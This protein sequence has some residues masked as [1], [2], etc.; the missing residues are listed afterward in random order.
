M[1]FIV[2]GTVVGPQTHYV[3]TLMGGGQTFGESASTLD[4]SGNM[5]VAGYYQA[6]F[7]GVTYYMLAKFNSLGSLQWQKQ[8]PI[9]NMSITS[10]AVDSSGNVYA[11]GNIRTALQYTSNQVIIKFDSS[12]NYIWKKQ[13]GDGDTVQGSNYT[14]QIAIS[15]SDDIYVTGQFAGTPYGNNYYYMSLVKYNTSGVVQWQRRLHQGTITTGG[16]GVTIDSSGNIYVVGYGQWTGA[17]SYNSAIIAKYDSTGTL[18][19]QQ[20]IAGT[21]SVSANY[22]KVACDSS[23]NVYAIG[24][25]NYSGAS[26]KVAIV[27]YNSSGT[28]QWGRQWGTTGTNNQMSA[29]GIKID[30]SDNLYISGSTYNSITS[31]YEDSIIAKYSSSGAIQWQRYINGPNMG[32]GPQLHLDNLTNFYIGTDSNKNGMKFVVAKLPTD[33]SKTATYSP[34]G[35]SYSLIYGTA[36]L[37]EASYSPNTATP[38]LTN[39]TSTHATADATVGSMSTPTWSAA[40]VTSASSGYAGPFGTILGGTGTGMVISSYVAPSYYIGTITG[41]TADSGNQTVA[42]NSGNSYVL[43]AGKIVKL[44]AAGSISW[45]K[46]YATTTVD[47]WGAVDSSDNLHVTYQNTVVKYD[48]SGTLQWQRSLLT[49]LWKKV[50]VDSSSNVYLIGH[51]GSPTGMIIAKYNSS[52]AIQW[53]R[54]LADSTVKE[55]WGI[56]VDSSGNVYISG[57]DGGNVYYIAK[58]N[59]SG[60]I[61]WQKSIANAFGIGFG[62]VRA[63]GG[64]VSVDSS[65]NPY[66]CVP[67]HYTVNSLASTDFHLIKFDSSGTVQWQ[68]RILG[69]TDKDDFLGGMALDS[70]GN[71]YMSIQSIGTYALT[72]IKYNSSGALQWQTKLPYPSGGT[73]YGVGGISIS[74]NK[75]FVAGTTN[76]SGSIGGI[77]AALPLDGT[78][79]GTYSL[80]TVTGSSVTYQTSTTYSDSAASLTYATSTLT[81]STPTLTEQAGTLTE[82]TPSLTVTTVALPTASSSATQKAIFGYGVTSAYVSMTN[83]VSNTGVVGNDVTGVGTARQSPAAAG[84]GGDKAIFG[85]GTTGTNT[86]ITNLVSNTGVVATDTAGVG[87]ARRFLAACGYGTDKAIFGY[88]Y[89]TGLSSITNLVS[90]TGV[91]GNDV[92]GVGTARYY[93]AACGYGTDKAIFGYG[94]NGSNLS[95]T[96]LVSNTGVVGNDVTGVGTA[97][98]GLAAAGYGTDKAIFG[99]GGAGSLTSITNLV[100]N[101]GVVAT[102]TTGVGTARQL[103]AAAGYGSDKAIFGYGDTGNDTAI[104]NLVSNTGVVATNTTGVGTARNS[105]AA[106]GYSL[107]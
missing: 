26:P 17:T 103:L 74:S 52:G 9:V 88:G 47:S 3:A 69:V 106:A 4:A 53:Q 54:K 66:L 11:A 93:I 89:S 92:T 67:L 30:S 99:Y 76:V 73:N 6:E 71:S 104:T 51:A 46:S 60:T 58:Y 1:G 59:S 42:D 36:N 50:A 33:G 56:A 72:I 62:Y 65:G 95:M 12:G 19:W 21:S 49:A 79:T 68:R 75:L 43:G 78:K 10:M 101:T 32:S 29:G 98:N 105:L 8:F 15:S 45:Q 16:N 7:Q 20:A 39:V 100:S 37:N 13:I 44:S 23:G 96:N 2:G 18:V 90:N 86:A 102:D 97:R 84:Y 83:L 64:V 82:S 55:G 34:G 48:S 77:I 85:Y 40:V 22:S 80:S 107:T 70:S 38:T 61:Q 87:T 25:L 5:Y 41:L 27:K 94:Y 28:V 57:A 91:V 81:A 31:S 24:L 35:S 14:A 63:P